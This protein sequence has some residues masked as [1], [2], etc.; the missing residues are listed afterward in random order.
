MRT[1]E[2]VRAIGKI[3]N[4]DELIS[5]IR[6]ISELS[7]DQYN[8]NVSIAS[9]GREDRE[10]PAYYGLLH[11]KG[12]KYPFSRPALKGFRS[13]VLNDIDFVD[14]VERIFRDGRVKYHH[15]KI[16]ELMGRTAYDRIMDY[17]L[18]TMP[19]KPQPWKKSG[20]RNLEDT[21]ELWESIISSVVDKKSGKIVWRGK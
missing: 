4:P 1:R 6:N 10:N 11:D 15:K 12:T 17:L 20:G 19:Q 3:K 14:E 18:Y 2:K 7:G 5:R 16:A 9:N 21:G 13:Y 8:I